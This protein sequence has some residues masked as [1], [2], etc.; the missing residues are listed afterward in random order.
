MIQRSV[1]STQ[2]RSR[3]DR[4]H[5]EADC[6]FDGV[7]HGR[8]AREPGGSGSRERASRPVSVSRVDAGPPPHSFIDPVPKQ[9]DCVSLEVPAFDECGVRPKLDESAGGHTHVLDRRDGRSDQDRGLV[10]VG[11]DQCCQ[12]HEPRDERGFRVRVEQ[13]GSA[14]ETMTGSMT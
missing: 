10:Q 3:L 11:R 14:V 8:A 6:S 5:D 7:V 1:A 4:P 12:G 9:V 2:S 13:P